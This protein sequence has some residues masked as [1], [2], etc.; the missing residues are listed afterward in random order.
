MFRVCVCVCVCVCVRART[1]ALMH[2]QSCPDL[3][4]PRDFGP[5]W[6]L[7]PWNFPR[8]NNEMGYHF[9]FYIQFNIV[10][11]CE[12]TVSVDLIK[13]YSCIGVQYTRIYQVKKIIIF[14]VL[15]IKKN[16]EDNRKS[17]LQNF[18]NAVYIYTYT[19]MIANSI[20]LV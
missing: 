8:K 15:K 3:Y 10:I 2:A 14:K 18:V 1:H 4:N 12:F 11:F 9:P 5:T 16:N 20:F 6:L 13:K 7:Y 19:P 17:W